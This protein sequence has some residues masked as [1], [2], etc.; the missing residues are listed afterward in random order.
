M[1][2]TSYEH[3]DF[4]VS[5]EDPE[6]A[7]KSADYRIKIYKDIQKESQKFEMIKVFGKKDSKNLVIGWGSTKCAILDAIK[8]ED[9]KFLQV[10]YMK[11]I[12][13]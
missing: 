8:G 12:S 4:G 9:F 10:L 3:D 13:D 6:I 11:P 7:K 2:Q 5:T 1:R